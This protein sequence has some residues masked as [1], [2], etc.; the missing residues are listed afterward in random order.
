MSKGMMIG[1][2]IC[3]VIGSILAII[4]LV[5]T[6]FFLFFFG[7][8]YMWFWDPFF[9]FGPQ[10]LI[11]SILMIVGIVMIIIGIPLTVV[12]AVTGRRRSRYLPRRRKRQTTVPTHIRRKEE[13]I[14]KEEWKE[15]AVICP[16]CGAQVHPGDII[17]SHC[18][19]RL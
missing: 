10:L 3:I 7:P 5:M 14:D 18:G 13:R 2:I 8:F 15:D 11:G 16:W 6:P 19:G 12:G 4:G 1:G 17:C 9:F